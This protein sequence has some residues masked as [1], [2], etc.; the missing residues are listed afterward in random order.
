M[1]QLRRRRG[2]R[3]TGTVSGPITPLALSMEA[4]A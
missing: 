4:V 2:M 3:P 1:T